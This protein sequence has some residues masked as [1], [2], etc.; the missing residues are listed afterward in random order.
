MN[1]LLTIL[2]V[3]LFANYSFGQA[4]VGSRVF[5][6][7]LKDGLSFG[8]VNSIT[9]DKKGFMWFATADGLNRFDGSEFKVFKTD[10]DN[11]NS[12]SANYVQ[13]VFK[14]S[15][16]ILWVSSRNGLSR[17]DPEK[18]QFI[19]QK[20]FTAAD[21][22]WKND[23]SHLSEGRDGRLW[24]AFSNSGFASFDKKTKKTVNYNT[25][26]LPGLSSNN[27]LNVY[28]DP[29]GLLWVG[30]QESGIN[31]F[32]IGSNKTLKKAFLNL[33]ELPTERINSVYEDH[34]H[35]IWIASSKG[36]A[37]YKRQENKF[38]VLHA[39]Q[40]HLRNDIFLSLT[41]KITKSNYWSDFKTVGCLNLI[42]RNRLQ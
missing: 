33:T 15:E 39:S 28:Q 37:L 8:V 36:L 34:S 13:T 16:G 20:F 4:P 3:V 21:E 27:I 31:V 24:I 6:Y 2:F 29:Y 12:L 41:E 22:A 5:H 26:N 38:Y 9:Q 30:T 35:N 7:S 40:Y 14:D 18:E 17:F 19:T 11:K 32:R 10:P 23:V 1:K 42:I 25:S